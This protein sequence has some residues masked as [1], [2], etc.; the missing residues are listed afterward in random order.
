MM[1]LRV[2]SVWKVADFTLRRSPVRS[3]LGST[4]VAMK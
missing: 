3:Y 4:P 2:V 1:L